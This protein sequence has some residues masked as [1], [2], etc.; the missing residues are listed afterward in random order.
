MNVPA[1]AA[2]APDGA[3]YP[4]TGIGDARI[5]CTI[6]RI[7]VSRPPGVSRRS[8]TSCAFSRCACARPRST[9]SAV[10]GPIT[11]VTSSPTAGAVAARAT[12]ATKARATVSRQRS[13]L[14][15]W[16][17]W[18]RTARKHRPLAEHRG[19]RLL[20]AL[21]RDVDR[22]LELPVASRTRVLWRVRDLD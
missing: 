10:A 12:H 8:T 9:Y 16:P 15:P 6:A 14:R 4:T 11:P 17:R 22:H 5:A 13:T 20:R 21:E 3:T 19:R 18:Q 1:L 2:R 7:E